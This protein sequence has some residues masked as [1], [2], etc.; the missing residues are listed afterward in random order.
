MPSSNLSTPAP[1]A[2]RILRLGARGSLLSRMQSEMVGRAIEAAHPGVRVEL[3]IVTTSG[4]LIQDRPLHEFGGKGLFTKELELALLRGE[5]DFAVHSFKDVPVTMPLVETAEARVQFAAVLSAEKMCGMCWSARRG[6]RFWSCRWGR[7]GGRG[8]C[9]G[10]RRCWRC[11]RIWTW[12][13]FGGMWI[14]G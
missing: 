5:I 6:G 12:C 3:V 8:L 9:G 11:G 4:D 7:G 2:Q 10:R 14:R 13:R 1:G